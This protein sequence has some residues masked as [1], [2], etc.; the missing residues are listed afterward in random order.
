MSDG[1]RRT[2]S[3]ASLLDLAAMRSWLLKIGTCPLSA[4]GVG[5]EAWPGF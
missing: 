3:R 5:S 4:T 1:Q 2:R